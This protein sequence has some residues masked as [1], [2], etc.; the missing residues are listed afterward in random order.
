[1]TLIGC[2]AVEV[3]RRFG[4]IYWEFMVKGCTNCIALIFVSSIWQTKHLFMSEILEC[5]FEDSMGVV[6]VLVIPL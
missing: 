3:V 2:F 6:H 5:V 1:M 4:K